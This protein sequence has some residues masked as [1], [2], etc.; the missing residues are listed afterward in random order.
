MSTYEIMRTCK[1]LWLPT[2]LIGYVL[3]AL[4]TVIGKNGF[5]H[6]WKLR[7]EQQTLE[8][9]AV[10]LLEEN[11]DLRDRISRLKTDNGYLEKVVREDLRY[12]KK[13]EI[14]YLFRSSP[15]SSEQD[16]E[17]A[18]GAGVRESTPEHIWSR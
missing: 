14:L 18:G 12:V 10:A 6:L 7:Q 13:E 16:G 5:V 17:R 9:T 4:S 1:K 2:L 8:S 11:K 3:L 15:E